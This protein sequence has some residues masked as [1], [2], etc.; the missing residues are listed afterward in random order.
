M[1]KFVKLT[2]LLPDGSY[3][4]TWIPIEDIV[5]LIQNSVIHE[6]E[7]RGICFFKNGQSIDLIAFNETLDS[8]K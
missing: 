3:E 8:L 5:Q 7:N 6:G 1:A 2:Q 4:R